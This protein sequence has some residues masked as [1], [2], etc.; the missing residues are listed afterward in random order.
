MAAIIK[1][2]LK[3]AI[4][5]AIYSEIESKQARYYY[6]LGRTVNFAVEGEEPNSSV[7]YESKVRNEMVLLKSLSAANISLVV[8]RNDWVSGKIFNAYNV[9]VDEGVPNTYCMIVETQ[10]VYKCL[11]NGGNSNPSIFPPSTTDLEPQSLADGYTWKFMYNIPRALANKFLTGE[12][13][14]VTTALRSRF[15]SNGSIDSISIEASG[16]G[17]TQGTTTLIVNGDGQDATMAPVIVGGQLVNVII[18]NAGI[19]YTNATITINSSLSSSVAFGA[20]ISV[21]LSTGNFTSSQAVVE[22]LSVPGTIDRI[23]T[24]SSGTG[25]PPGTTLSIQGDGT[26]ATI[27]Y[28]LGVG[29]ELTNIQM[30]NVGQDYTV[31]NVVISTVPAEGGIPA[32]LYANISPALGHGRDAVAELYA[33]S[34]M[35]FGNLTRESYGGVKI[36]NDYRQYGLIRNPRGLTF[37]TNISDPISINSYALITQF[38]PGTMINDF[39]PGTRL[40]DSITNLYTVTSVVA[41]ATRSGMTVTSQSGSEIT[42]SMVLTSTNLWSLTGTYST[43]FGDFPEGTVCTDPSL[44]IVFVYT[45]A[46]GTMS[47]YT[48]NGTPITAGMVLTKAIGTGPFPT[49]TIGVATAT[50]KSL[51]VENSQARAKLDSDIGSTCYSV[52]GLFNT[53]VWAADTVVQ[54]GINEFL[55]ISTDTSIT[56]VTSMLLLPRDSGTISVGNVINIKNTATSFTATAVL[57]PN[58]DKNTGDILFIDNRPSF[59]QTPDQAVSFRTVIEF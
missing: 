27:S 55:I 30:T 26:G 35:F 13:M 29:G 38:L 28:T 6:Y 44:N 53:T 5:D 37:G 24:N 12:F 16:Q 57:E 52:S 46:A 54:R 2:K 21:N 19:G 3:Q 51:T 32:L 11:D 39:P 7:D 4:A 25:Y 20:Q 14:P 34:I 41:G 49:F 40:Q 1:Q 15:F 58:I 59:I 36:N 48:A 33:T 8:P 23:V 56:G 22:M 31:A 42:N 50:V 17:Y 18:T 10:N 45:S 9:S 47:I 43:A